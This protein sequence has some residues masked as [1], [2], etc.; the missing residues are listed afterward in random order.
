MRRHLTARNVLGG[1]LNWKVLKS[2]TLSVYCG[3]C[4]V[5]LLNGHTV[6]A[7]IS[8]GSLGPEF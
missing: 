8:V 3:S 4:F 1:L 5:T 6:L 2:A 7:D